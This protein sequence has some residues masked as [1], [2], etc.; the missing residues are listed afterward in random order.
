MKREIIKYKTEEEWLAL[1]LDDITSTMTPALFDMSPYHTPFDLYHA[2]VSKVE[3]PFVSNHRIEVGSRMEQFAG[4]EV[5]LIEKWIESTEP[6]KEYIR[7]PELRIGSSFDRRGIDTQGK[8]FIME[9]KAV[10][11]FQHK[12]KWSEDEAP[13]HIEF[14]AQHELMVAGDEYDY[15]VIVVF[16]G[17]YDYHIIKREHDKEMQAGMLESIAE[18][19]DDVDNKREPKPDYIRDNPIIKELYQQEKDMGDFEDDEEFN[20]LCSKYKRLNEEIKQFENDK[21][22]TQSQLILK[23]GNYAGGFG[24]GWKMKMT[25]VKETPDS[26]VTEDMVG[27]KINGRK[28]FCYPRVTQLK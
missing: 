28:G 22:A 12:E 20:T 16:T 6:L 7:I 19:W 15:I 3:V 23:I 17:I 11:Y 26:E 9:I 13:V 4:E 21:T 10:D 8:R 25:N 2:K 14:Q 5:T 18:F 24:D 27:D 1:R